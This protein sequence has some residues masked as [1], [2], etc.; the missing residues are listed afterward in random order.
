MSKSTQTSERFNLSMP[1]KVLEIY[2][3][4]QSMKNFTAFARIAVIEKLNRDF[5]FKINP[6]SVDFSQGK[7][8]D[9]MNPATKKRKLPA[10]RRQAARARQKKAELPGKQ[11]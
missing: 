9:L 1:K 4:C 11:I 8:T 3:S 2:R 10:L 7:R 6:E 5:G